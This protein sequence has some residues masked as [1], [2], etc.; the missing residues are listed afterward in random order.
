[1]LK[2]IINFVKQRK[3][4]DR[5]LLESLFHNINDKIFITNQSGQIINSSQKYN[6]FIKQIY[7]K[8][9]I[10][11]NLFPEH[12]S[13]ESSYKYKNL[14]KYL[15]KE[16]KPILNYAL[17]LMIDNM[18]VDINL[19]L[20]PLLN[21]D[22]DNLC[23]LHFI[24]K[25]KETKDTEFEL[26]HIEKLTNI[27][28]VAA[29]M[30]HELNTPL[31]SIILSSEII[32]KETTDKEII[33]EINSI[34]QRATHCSKVVREL[35]N[36]VRKDVNE[37][38]EIDLIVILKKIIKLVEP[39]ARKRDIQIEIITD[40]ETYKMKCIENKIEQ[41]FFNLF[42]NSIFAIE[43]QGVISIKLKKDSLYN[44]TI[45]MFTDSGGGISENIMKNIFDPFFTTKPSTQGTGLGLALCQKIILEHGG[46]IYVESKIN[47]GTTFIIKF[48]DT[49]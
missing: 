15:S 36:Y 43:Q 48:P 38:K 41:L 19:S 2:G 33:E 25:K 4:N 31:G 35:L 39:D 22:K 34:K 8:S 26:G 37:Y 27:G 20:F 5:I 14:I 6:E 10:R 1:M 44:K 21:Y 24:Y 7:E 32:L 11:Y 16:D 3:F 17:E 28:Q 46:D 49:L 47:H 18:P 45:I 30:A 12:L 13:A 42:S 40:N 9:T 23:Y 29:G